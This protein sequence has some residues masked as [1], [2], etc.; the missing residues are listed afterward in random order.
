MINLTEFLKK[1]Y[2]FGNVSEIFPDIEQ[3]KFMSYKIIEPDLNDET[4]WV[5]Q[6]QIA[7]NNKNIPEYLNQKI[8]PHMVSLS[9]G[10]ERKEI[11]YEYGLET[12]SHTLIQKNP[13]KDIME[14]FK[15]YC[16]KYVQKI[17][18]REE[19]SDFHQ[20][21]QCFIEG[22]KLNPHTDSHNGSDCVLILYLS[23]D[24]WDNNGGELKIT[25][26]GDICK[27]IHGNFSLLDLTKNDIRHE[28]TTVT[29]AFKRYSYLF[30]PSIKK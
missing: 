16:T 11:V 8:L 2:Y 26:T 17:Y 14:Y 30:R 5:C 20:S 22:S 25:N 4:H 3:F 23:N 15:N 9:V 12:I 19:Y 1:G 28:V 27:P 10:E 6:Q 21:I 24:I 18:N 13:N 7:T 29:G